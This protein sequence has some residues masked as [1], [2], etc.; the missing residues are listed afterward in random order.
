LSLSKPGT[1]LN[2]LKPCGYY[3]YTT[4]CNTLTLCFLPTEYICCSVRFSQ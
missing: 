2:P 1:I 4:C 3:M